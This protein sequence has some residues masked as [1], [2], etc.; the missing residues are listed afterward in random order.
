MSGMPFG[1]PPG[2]VA[3][4]GGSMAIIIRNR[5]HGRAV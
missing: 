2:R 4:G 3:A 1:P 5:L